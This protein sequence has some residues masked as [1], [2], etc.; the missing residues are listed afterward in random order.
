MFHMKHNC[1]QC[2][3]WK[4]FCEAGKRN[5]DFDTGTCHRYPPFL[6][7]VYAKNERGDT[8]DDAHCYTQPIT[9]ETDWCGEF[10]QMPNP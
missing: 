2:M 8:G 1:G 9:E 6:D 10:K 3:F 4:M 7:V 5:K